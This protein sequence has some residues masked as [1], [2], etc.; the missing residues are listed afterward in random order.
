MKSKIARQ[1][2]RGK[3]FRPSYSGKV[4]LA[5]ALSAI[6]VLHCIKLF[7]GRLSASNRLS[8][9]GKADLDAARKEIIYLD[10]L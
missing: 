4:G 10:G 3:G 2:S 9:D 6:P 7:P 5:T 8:T 1:P